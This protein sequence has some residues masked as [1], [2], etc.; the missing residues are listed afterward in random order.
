ML[1]LHRR[2]ALTLAVAA[3]VAGCSSVGDE[4]LGEFAGESSGATTGDTDA[5]DEGSGLTSGD[6]TGTT[7][8]GDGDPTTDP[9]GSEPPPPSGGGDELLAGQWRD[10]DHW[11]FWT[12]LLTAEG[13][14]GQLPAHWGFFTASSRIPVTVVDGGVPLADAAV[15]LFDRDDQVVW[16]SRTDADG[17][18][19]LYTELFGDE[20]AA[21]LTVRVLDAFEQSIA[22]VE[23]MPGDPVLL[24]VQ[25]LTPPPPVLDLMLVIDTTTSMA[26]ELAYL[27]H[28]LGSVIEGVRAGSEDEL[29]IRI[30][31]NFYR[32]D[33]EAYVLRSFPF[34]EN[35][36]EALAQLAEQDA[37]GG[38]DFPEAVDAALADAV[39]DHEWSPRARARVL[40]L[41]LDAPPHHTEESLASLRASTLQA[42][43][44]G[45]RVVPIGG[46]DID[47]P[48]EFLV[49]FID[50]ATNG[51]FVFVTGDDDALEDSSAVEFNKPTVGD[52]ELEPLADLLTR[53]LL[54]AVG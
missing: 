43:A 26:D 13:P 17:E 35:V 32:D 24:D 30:S 46:S 31:V 28:K 11:D 54:D 47:E 51:T 40:L 4:D 37:D 10:I 34:T 8:E 36:E 19:Q 49:R 39:L 53:L 48:T 1:W 14:W 38:G 22:D 12:Q 45:I 5:G 44:Q 29:A 16:R 15:V 3:L 18:A 25:G 2:L 27:Q 23:A 20:S 7:G 9:T 42:A 52:I 21:P 41:V 50:I 6:T 33:A